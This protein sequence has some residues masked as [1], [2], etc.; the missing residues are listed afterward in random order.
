VLDSVLDGQT[1]VVAFPFDPVPVLRA[2]AEGRL[3]ERADPGRF[4][5]ELTGDAVPFGSAFGETRAQ[6]AASWHH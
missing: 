5:I 1:R 6:A 2:L 4:E 3:P